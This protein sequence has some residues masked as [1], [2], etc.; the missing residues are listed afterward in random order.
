M[1]GHRNEVVR[2]TPRRT[3]VRRALE[4]EVTASRGSAGVPVTGRLTRGEASVGPSR[5]ARSWI[6]KTYKPCADSCS[7][8]RVNFDEGQKPRRVG[9]P[10]NRRAH[11]RPAPREG[12]VSSGSTGESQSSYGLPGNGGQRLRSARGVVASLP[13]EGRDW[14]TVR[15]E[16][17]LRGPACGAP[18]GSRT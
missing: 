10:G 17:R 3:K 12:Q 9:P 4:S 6:R 14:S 16:M 2:G 15:R 1:L 11:H 8:L 18:P 13:R 7:H 5:A